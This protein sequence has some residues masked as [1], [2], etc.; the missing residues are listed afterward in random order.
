[1]HIICEHL[2]DLYTLNSLSGW[3]GLKKFIPRDPLNSPLI[4]ILFSMSKPLIFKAYKSTLQSTLQIYST[5]LLYKSTLQ[6]YSTN[7]L[8]K[9]ILILPVTYFEL[10]LKTNVCSCPGLKGTWVIKV[11]HRPKRSDT[12]K[13]TRYNIMHNLYSCFGSGIK[14][15]AQF[16]Q[17]FWIWY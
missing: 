5:N 4:F 15:H 14:H 6:I 11:N 16:I 13:L 8:Y 2:H 1:M 10:K 7:L 3:K 12:K 17:L 9:S